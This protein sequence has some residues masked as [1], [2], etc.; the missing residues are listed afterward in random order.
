MGRLIINADDYG[1]SKEVTKG[2]LVGHEAGVITSTTMMV[3]GD[4]AEKAVSLLPSSLGLGLHLNL[5]EGMSLLDGKKYD[6]KKRYKIFLGIVD[7]D[8]VEKEFRLQFEFFED[9]GLKPSHVDSHYNIHAFSPITEIAVRLAK[10][11]KVEKM[12]WPKERLEGL[13]RSLVALKAL[14]VSK[15]LKDC[16]L[17]APDHHFGFVHRGDPQIER[18]LS[19]L[20]FEG[21]A[22]LGVH[23]SSSRL[24][25]ID[26]KY[27]DKELQVLLHHR[28][29]EGLKRVEL[30]SYNE[31]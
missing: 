10:E 18:F 27:Y 24:N 19:Y 17:V 9:I 5:L 13:P 14:I 23:V 2:V 1:V 20:D 16:P 30:I 22:E 31:L 28:F 12:R 15:K 8:W 25:P 29:K 11:Y 26:R 6:A 3:G 21:S 7:K 4:Y